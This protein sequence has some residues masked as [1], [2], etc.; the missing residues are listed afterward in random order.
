MTEEVIKTMKSYD[1]ICNYIHLP[2]QSGSNKILKLMNRG[3]TRE[4]YINLIDIIK[5]HIQTVD[6][7][8]T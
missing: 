2:V 1:N 4:E 8:W 5:K 7:Q 3:Y 6:Y